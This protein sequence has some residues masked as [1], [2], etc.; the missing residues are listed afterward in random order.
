MKGIKFAILGVLFSSI[1]LSCQ[2]QAKPLYKIPEGK[3]NVEVKAE[4]VKIVEK[5]EEIKNSVAV[6]A[7]NGNGL[8]KI[9]GENSVLGLWTEGSVSQIL[10]T[11]NVLENG[12]KSEKWYFVTSKGILYSED[13][14][15]FELR[16]NGIADV[17]IKK[18]DSQT[19]SFEKQIEEIKDISVDPSNSEIL[20]TA[21]K[22]NVYITYDGALSWKSLG[23]MSK[24]TSGIKAVA[25]A[26]LPRIS[27]GRELEETELVVFMSHPYF[28]LA[29]LYPKREKP[30]W[31]D[32]SSGFKIMPS[33]SYPDEIS[34]ILPVLTKDENGMSCVQIYMAQSFLPNI[35]KFDWSG[36]KGKNVYS[37]KEPSSTIDSL[38]FDGTNLI[39]TQP[40]VVNYF[41]SVSSAEVNELNTAEK[42]SLWKEKFDLLK[43]GIMT[44]WIPKELSCFEKDICLGELWLLYPEKMKSP[45]KDQILDKKSLYIPPY[46]VRKQLGDEGIDKFISNK[47]KRL[48]LV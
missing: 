15:N 37:G 28:G 26:E 33:M 6:I 11:E 31:I 10:K 22:N 2:T 19:E 30:V 16:N 34:D 41:D 4:E 47:G 35:Y 29:Y 21:T 9:T 7:G 14:I 39:F 43:N 13:L 3:K 42:L 20:V 17:V 25:V 12:T 40:K 48:L 32:V 18:Y 36:K 27:G 46:Q 45:Y 24:A 8:F 23:S 38:A 1:N 5:S 44:A